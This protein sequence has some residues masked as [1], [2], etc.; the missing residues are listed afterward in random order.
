MFWSTSTRCVHAL[1]LA[2]TCRPRPSSTQ[3]AGWPLSGQAAVLSS[4]HSDQGIQGKE[5]GTGLLG[6]RRR[7]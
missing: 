6:L 1:N 7:G 3:P 5:E 2:S 4:H